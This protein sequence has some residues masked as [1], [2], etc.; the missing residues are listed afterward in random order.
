MLTSVDGHKMLWILNMIFTGIRSVIVYVILAFGFFQAESATLA[1]DQMRQDVAKL[2]RVD[3]EEVIILKDYREYWIIK[4]AGKKYKVYKKPLEVEPQRL[5]RLASESGIGAA[6]VNDKILTVIPGHPMEPDDLKTDV[7]L[8][9]F[10]IF[11]KKVHALKQATA[12][13]VFSP[14]TRG[15]YRIIVGDDVEFYIVDFTRGGEEDLYEALGWLF[16]RF[17]IRGT[18]MMV[19][20]AEYLGHPPT[21]DELDAIEGAMTRQGMGLW[22]YRFG[23]RR[24][25]H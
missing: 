23:G 22:A 14:G 9:K 15:R 8:R 18:R 2:L 1:D 24:A 11:S 25:P 21:P 10:A 19:F 13:R 6:L 7:D 12:G 20:L 5:I 17:G 4:V 3:P 16:L